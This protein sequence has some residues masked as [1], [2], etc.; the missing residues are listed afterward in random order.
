MPKYVLSYFNMRGRGEFN[1]LLFA[2][3][4][5]EY[6]DHRI[7]RQQWPELRPTMPFH[8]LP[9]LEV[10]GVRICQSSAIGS[11]LAHTYGI[12]GKTV[13]DQARAVMIVECIND[14]LG[15][16]L[17]DF[18]FETD[19]VKRKEASEK[20][21]AEQVTPALVAL[22]KMLIENKGG[23]G[24][25]VGDDLTWADVKL[26]AYVGVLQSMHIDSVLDKVPKLKALVQRI[27]EL[28]RIKAYLET[29]PDSPY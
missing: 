10:D 19:D 12:A 2:A 25:L 8:Q 3:L 26:L 20:Y 5:V 6:Q 9:V 18:I 15:K 13:V 11:Y 24:Y 17:R 7:E 23:D 16:N 4:G 14:V 28:P 22:E 29:R 1:R 27:T 21:A